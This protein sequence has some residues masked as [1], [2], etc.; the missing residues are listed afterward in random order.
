MAQLL[1]AT[2]RLVGI[3]GPAVLGPQLLA[4]VDHPL[5]ASSL[6]EAGPQHVVQLE[7]VGDVGSRVVELRGLQR[8]PQPV[9]QAIGLQRLV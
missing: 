1:D 7:Q 6:G 3:A 8:P 9:G 5:V 2:P 4:R